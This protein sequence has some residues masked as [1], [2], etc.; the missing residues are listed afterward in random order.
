VRENV[1]FVHSSDFHLDEPIRGLRKLPQQLLETLAEA[2]YLAAQKVFD[3]AITEKVD[4]VLLSG[5]LCNLENL[6]AR[7]VAFL[8]K[9]FERLEQKNIWVYWCGGKG[10][11]PNHWPNAIKLPKNVFQFQSRSVEHVDYQKSGDSIVRV[12]GVGCDS[13]YVAGDLLGVVEDGVFNVVIAHAD[14]DVSAFKS[15]LID[16]WAFGG[17]LNSVTEEFENSVAENSVVVYPGSPQSRE[18]YQGESCGFKLVKLNQSRKTNVRTIE[19]DRVFWCSQP[20]EIPNQI[21]ME[22]VKNRLGEHA[23]QL[24]AEH[25]GQTVLCRWRLVNGGGDS[26]PQI[27]GMEWRAALL[28]WLRVEFG[29]SGDSLWSISLEEGSS[30]NFPNEWYEEDTLLGEYLRAIGRYQCDRDLRLNLQNYLKDDVPRWETDGMAIVNEQQ[31]DEILSEASLLGV[32]CLGGHDDP[33]V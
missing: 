18:F 7:S 9:Q 30:E 8:I 33:A 28:E 1:K 2:P 3:T 17:K 20:V 27:Y 31:R 13:K 6:S 26:A 14:A 32:E 29:R 24:M 15:D 4:F 19:S 10:D 16:Y 23:L 5:G 21:G 25:P 12:I 22:A 11:S